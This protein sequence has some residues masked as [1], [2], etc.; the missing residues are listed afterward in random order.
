MNQQE[1]MNTLVSQEQE[2]LRLKDRVAELEK[3]IKTIVDTGNNKWLTDQKQRLQMY[4][5]ARAE[6]Y[7]TLPRCQGR[8]V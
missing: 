7:K 5:L 1:I 4:E 2:I 3:L 8:G 6:I